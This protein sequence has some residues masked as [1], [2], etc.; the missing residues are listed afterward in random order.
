[1]PEKTISPRTNTSFMD[2]K[3]L[4]LTRR[5]IRKYRD[6]K[7]PEDLLW[8]VFELC[9]YSPTSKNTQSYY[10]IVVERK[11][12]IEKLASLRLP[13]SRPIGAAPMAVAICSDPSL[14]RRHVDDACIA[15]YHFMLA[16]WTYGLGTCWIAAMDRPEVK[17]LLGIPENHYVATVTPL[18]YPAHVPEPPA[19][20]PALEFVHGW[21][22]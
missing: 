5:S 19:R 10:F 7:P 15:A 14:S 3:E 13:Y 22:R 9:R 11:D 12:I 4:L 2:A 16:A 6:E 20:K 17:E 21:I 1:M 18:G 8:E